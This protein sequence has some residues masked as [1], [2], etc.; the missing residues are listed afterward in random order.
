MAVYVDFQHQTSAQLTAWPS[1]DLTSRTWCRSCCSLKRQPSVRDAWQSGIE[2]ATRANDSPPFRALFP[3]SGH[4]ASWLLHK[5]LRIRFTYYANGNGGICGVSG[6]AIHQWPARGTSPVSRHRGSRRLSFLPGLLNGFLECCKL[7]LHDLAGKIPDGFSGGRTDHPALLPPRR[8]TLEP[9]Y[10]LRQG[11][12]LMRFG[13][14]HN[15]ANIYCLQTIRR[16][17]TILIPSLV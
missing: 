3:A 13:V 14:S 9:R 15:D 5:D 7:Q 6:A 12:V 10:D 1:P 17:A 16:P 2:G 11:E 4:L 8:R